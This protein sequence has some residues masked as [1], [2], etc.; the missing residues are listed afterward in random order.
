MT[1]VTARSNAVQLD[2]RP[3]PQPAPAGF[4]GAVGQFTLESTL[5]PEHPKTGEPVTWTL[6]LSGTGNWPSGVA[7]PARA[8]PSDLR[9]LQPKQRSSFGD[10]G[11]FSG[12]VSEDLVIVPNQPGELALAPVQFVYFN[13]ESGRYETAEARPP[14]V[15]VTGA[16][17]PATASCAGAGRRR[18]CRSGA[19]SGGAAARP[20]SPRRSPAAG[21]G[22]APLPWSTLR[23][24]A[25]RALRAGDRRAPG[26]PRLARLAPRIPAAWR[27]ARRAGCAPTIIAARDA[28]S[29]EARIAALLDW[30]REA[31]RVLAID[32]A[33]PT[34]EQLR[35][36]SDPRWAEAWA[37]SERAL[38]A[39]GH[40]LPADWCAQALAL[41]TPPR[42]RRDARAPARQRPVLATA[43]TASLLPDR[44]GAAEPRRRARRRRPG[45]TRCGRRS[46]P[47]RSIG[48]RATTS[49]SP[50]RRPATAAAPSARPSPRWHRRRA[51]RP[52]AP[53][54]G[55]SPAAVPGAD[56]ALAPLLD[57]RLASL[58]APAS[59]QLILI[60][61]AVLAAAG[62]AI[63]R[64]RTVGAADRRR[65]LVL[66]VAAGLALREQGVFA[67]RRVALVASATRA[68]RAAD[69]R[70]GDRRGAAAGGGQRRPRR[71]RLPRLGAGD[72]RRRQRRLG[73]RRRPGAALRRR[74]RAAGQRRGDDMTRS[75][76]R[77]GKCGRARA[78]VFP[79]IT[80]SR[81]PIQTEKEPEASS[82]VH[83][84]HEE[85][86]GSRRTPSH[87]AP[88][89]TGDGAAS[90]SAWP[91]VS[92]GSVSW[93]RL[94]NSAVL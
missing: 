7:L 59:W 52:C 83:R 46:T 18:G 94:L 66:I 85:H 90:C 44:A 2:V 16:P 26:A 13:P 70:R 55:R 81:W 31:A 12:E 10:N 93:I 47:R 28:A 5:T 67:D 89:R 92:R 62:I 22:I 14:T 1:S 40:S 11:R 37:G 74:R 45:A 4:S 53:T 23:L 86:E 87:P 19:R 49:A 3:L 33:A 54:P 8:V 82:S 32:L 78:R 76:S 91:F 72:A 56:A 43:A 15:Q 80:T 68:A 17:L 73:A 35:G 34:A 20:S 61:G 21:T 64:R 29:T 27:G 50:R 41:C 48:W 51:S 30:Q 77:L 57:G 65:L 69:R 79:G 36:I 38:F 39:R 88:P 60:A 9:T 42:R 25:D 71:A 84:L 75:R 6:T 24:L 63:A 58:A